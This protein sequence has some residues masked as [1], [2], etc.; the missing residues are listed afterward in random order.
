MS[1]TCVHK[2]TARVE[3]VDELPRFGELDETLLEV[4]ERSLDQTAGLLVVVQ[5][6]VPQRLAGQHL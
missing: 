4:G 6:V 3:A 5:Q 1:F 2:V